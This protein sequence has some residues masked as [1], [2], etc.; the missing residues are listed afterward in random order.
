M[1]SSIKHLLVYVSAVAL[2]TCVLPGRVCAQTGANPYVIVA[3]A[4]SDSDRGLAL[5]AAYNQA[6]TMSPSAANRITVLIPPGG[7][8]FWGHCFTVDTPYIDLIGMVPV[9]MT[10]RIKTNIVIAGVSTVVE[11][12]V[13]KPEP[14]GGL[15]LYSSGG[16]YVGV[17]TQT[18]SHVRIANM[19][20]SSLA[21]GP[22]NMNDAAGDE[23]AAY[24]PAAGLQDVT[25]E[26]VYFDHSN[27]FSMSYMGDY[28]GVYRDCVA[29]DGSFGMG[30]DTTGAASGSFQDCVAGD[31]SFGAED[32]VFGGS[33]NFD[34]CTGGYD[35]FGG[36]GLATGH[37]AHCIGGYGSFGGDGGASSGLFEDCYAQDFSFGGSSVFSPTPG[38]Y[39]NCVGGNYS[40]GE[41]GPLKGRFEFCR[42]G[43]VSFSGSQAIDPSAVLVHC[44]GGANSFGQYNT[45]STD[46][47]YV[48]TTSDTVSSINLHGQTINNGVF[49]GNGAGL[50]GVPG[51]AI[52]G[53]VHVP[54]NIQTDGQFVGNGSALLISQQG[55]LSMGPFTAGPHP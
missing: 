45:S 13:A 54:G 19:V 37:F 24:W 34:H 23:P 17:I 20:L 33:G 3:D 14:Q 47:N 5:Q 39:K 35:S 21:S 1:N 28:P 16:T 38:V 44:F 32:M 6:K 40:F 7:Y 27:C 10:M 43:A 8:Y 41:Y 46:F 53:A 50:V 25:I 49:N 22:T 31:F 26:H 29:G 2:L 48:G 15:R 9:Q 42:G 18:A 12:T 36:G 51:S 30:F 52:T 4:T 11:M 55:D